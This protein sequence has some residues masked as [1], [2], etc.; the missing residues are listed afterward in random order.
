VERTGG[1]IVEDWNITYYPTIYV[2]DAEGIIRFKDQKGEFPGAKLEE[3]VND[4]LKKQAL[5]K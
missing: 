1:G 2:I 5:S 4:L 3:A